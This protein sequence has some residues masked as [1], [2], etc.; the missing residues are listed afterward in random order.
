MNKFLNLL[1]WRHTARQ[2]RKRLRL[3]VIVSASVF[4]VAGEWGNWWKRDNQLILLQKQGEELG[5]QYK[6]IKKIFQDKQGDLQQNPAWNTA[7]EGNV[8]TPQ[9]EMVLVTLAEELPENSWL[10]SVSW[11]S[12]VM[13]LEGYT[14]EI[15]D[16]EKI[17]MLLKQIPGASHVRAGPVSYQAA[18]GLFYTFRLEEVGGQVV[19]L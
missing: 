1:P 7:L 9:W 15:G 10:R 13:V 12:G 17:E 6:K 18:Q 11:Q 2:R 19:S 4:L 16:L 3:S 14:T 8:R 5:Y